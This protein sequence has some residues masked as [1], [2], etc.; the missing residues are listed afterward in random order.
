MQAEM[1]GLQL[2]VF[3]LERELGFSKA[4][5]FLSGKC[6]V[7]RKENVERFRRTVET[8]AGRQ[9]Q[10]LLYLSLTKLAEMLQ[11]C[12]AV[13]ISE[14]K[15]RKIRLSQLMSRNHPLNTR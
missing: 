13:T 9:S 4:S 8:L 6:P 15:L 5:L 14:L 3:N 11:N 12:R 2:V 1:A 10:K 7:G